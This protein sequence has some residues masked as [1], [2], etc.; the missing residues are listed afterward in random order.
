M[1]NQERALKDPDVVK[2]DLKHIKRVLD[3]EPTTLIDQGIEKT[4]E[5]YK[6]NLELLKSLTYINK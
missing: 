5:W 1:I 2:P 3:W 4:V 6:Q